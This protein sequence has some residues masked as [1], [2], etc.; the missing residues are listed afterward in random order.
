MNFSIPRNNETE[1]LLYL[2]KV[3]DLPFLYEEELLYALSFDL[4]LIP[5]EKAQEFIK[6]SLNNHLLTKNKYSLISLTEDLE[7]KLEEWNTKRKEE[8]KSKLSE[9]K[10]VAKKREIA[11]KSKFGPI[12]KAMSDKGSINRAVSI[13][14]DAVNLLDVNF[15]IGQIKAEIAGT[16]EEPYKVEIDSKKMVIIHDCHDFM[17]R[18][19]KEKKFCKHIVKL[20]LKLKESDDESVLDFLEKMVQNISKWEFSG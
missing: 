15:D 17:T 11:V 12:L 19:S 13:K 6:K 18:K 9:N 20:F 3:M 2:W 1:L 5:P 4:F 10:K 7:K 14:N 8:I 16:K